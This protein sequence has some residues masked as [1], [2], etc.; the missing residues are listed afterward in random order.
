MKSGDSMWR[1]LKNKNVRYFI[2][3]SWAVAWPMILIMFF[4]S[5]I[6]MTDVFVAGRIGKDIQAAYG[7]AIQIYLIFSIVANALTV[8]TVSIV[9][10]LYSANDRDQ[11]STAVF[12]S[13][14]TAAAAGAVLAAVGV[15]FAPFLIGLSNIPGQLKPFCAPLVQIYCVGVVFQ[16]LLITCN[17]VLRS[18]DR[19]KDSFR[20]M[21]VVCLFN[22]G[23]NLFFVFCTPLGFRGIALATATS[24]FIGS[25]MNLRLV[26]TKIMIGVRTFSRG[27]IGRVFKIGWPMGV[28]QILWQLG[29][30][31]LF[32]ILSE[33][34]ANKVET[35]AAFTAGLRIESF[36]Y[37]PA[38]AFNM[39]NAVIVGNLL[40]E[41]K[42]EE[43]YKSGI[44]T[45]LVGV[46]LIVVLV[47][48]VIT[49]AWWITSFLSTNPVVVRESV[50]YIY[51]ALIS[52]PFMAFGIILGGGLGG[53]GDTR[54]VMIRIAGS[55]WLVR[56]PLAYLL[57]VVF[58]FGAAAVW[59]SMN[60]SQFVQ[61][62]FMYQRYSKRKWLVAAPA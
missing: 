42:L 31:V 4:E 8:G 7:F 47:A 46:S 34:P 54:S 56:L 18:C 33:L 43:A 23:L 37:M 9:S 50:K 40:G 32:L 21:T 11:L 39:A 17:G 12:S 61:A 38:F 22:V 26:A 29:S 55:V 14:V 27:V 62:F 49:N 41:K 45:A 10:R 13:M 28:V 19:I 48:I 51:I 24:V 1:A 60:I 25:M 53:A 36:I 57:V 5:I 44:I 52:E 20:T 16:Y 59:W 6:G 3:R 2:S 15:L 58:G 35:I 30:M